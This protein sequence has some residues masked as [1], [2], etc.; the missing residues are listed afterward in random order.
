M[1]QLAYFAG[2]GNYGMENG[3]FVLVDVSKWIQSD[4]EKIEEALD[5]ERPNIAYQISEGYS[6]E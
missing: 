2:D 4:W 3:N 6:N 5:W 1:T